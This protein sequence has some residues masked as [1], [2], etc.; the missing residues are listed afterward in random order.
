VSSPNPGPY[1]T[2]YY[3]GLPYPIYNPV[4]TLSDTLN[5]N[6]SANPNTNRIKRITLNIFTKNAYFINASLQ[7]YQIDGSVKIVDTFF[8]PD[9]FSTNG[10]SK[11]STTIVYEGARL[12]TL[13]LTK[14]LKYEIGISA[15]STVVRLTDENKFRVTIGARAELEYNIKD[16][17][18]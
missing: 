5:F 1:G 14:T 10:Q 8:K 18:L 7:I 15:T 11:N 13:K 17:N 16:L 12:D 4:F 2:F 3:N 6:L 9:K